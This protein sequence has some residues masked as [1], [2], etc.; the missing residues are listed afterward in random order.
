MSDFFVFRQ[1]SAKNRIKMTQ[2]P[3]NAS[4]MD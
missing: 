2:N 4:K 3:K 1:K